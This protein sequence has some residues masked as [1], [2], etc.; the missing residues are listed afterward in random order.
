MFMV[1][2][3]MIGVVPIDDYCDDVDDCGYDQSR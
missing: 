1:V 3:G 2:M